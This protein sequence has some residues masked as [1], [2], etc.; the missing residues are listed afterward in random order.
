MTM[1]TSVREVFRV[2]AAAYDRG[3]P[4][5][6]VE[7][8]ESQALLPVLAGRDVLDLGAGTGHYA[9]LAR[10]AGARLAVALDLTFEMLARAARPAV[11]ADA[12]RLPLRSGA[13]DVVV[14]ALVTSYLPDPEGAFR[15]AARV[16]RP[17]G[18]LVLS[19]LHPVA[20]RL[21]WRR[22][23]D[24]ADG[25]T[26]EAAGTPHPPERLSGWLEACGLLLEDRREP[27]I[28]GRLAGHFRAAGRRDF[29]DLRGT[30]LLVVLR[31]RKRGVHAG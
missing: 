7:R 14:A 1:R 31:A 11:V 25:G 6:A 21:G 29:E 16:L 4:L 19:D 20:S 26:V 22:V 30:P 3:N 10:A 24:T 8:P 23:F 13:M 28:D 9:A 18:M 5:L 12:A 27:V 15:E 17:G 2:A